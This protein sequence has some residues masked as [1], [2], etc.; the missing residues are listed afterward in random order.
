MSYGQRP[1]RIIGV[2][3]EWAAYQLDIATQQWGAWVEGKLH[4]TDKQGKPVHALAALLAEPGE[5]GEQSD[6]ERYATLPIDVS[7]LRKVRVKPDG[8]WDDE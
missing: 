7:Q 4:E 5:P 6:A 1:S 2:D 3:D 8:T